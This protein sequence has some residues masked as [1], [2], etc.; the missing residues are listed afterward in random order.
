MTALT[1]LVT[2]GSG[3]LGRPL[4]DQLR[5]DRPG[6]RIV[7]IGR[8]IS[9]AWPTVDFQAADLESDDSL[10]EAVA[11]I[12]PDRVV[13]LAGRTPPASADQ[14]Y[15]SNVIGTLKLLDALRALDR[16]MRIVLAGSAAEL[17]PVR[18]ANL[19]VGEDAPCHPVGPYG[20]SKFLATTAGLAA[21]PPLE[22]AVARVF[23]P[24]GPGMPVSQAFGRFASALASGTGPI[25]LPVGDLE[26]RRDFIDVRD[27]ARGLLA[28]IER[29]HCGRVY[30]VGTGRSRRVGDGL[31]TLIALSGREVT[32]EAGQAPPSVPADSRADIARI[33]RETGWN[34][35]VPWE[36]S[37]RD[38][39]DEAVRQARPRD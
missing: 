17:G 20:L 36:Q 23:N 7:A 25:R 1:W 18:E 31:D 27:V 37:L 8:S 12:R 29:G 5:A 3:F 35:A 21:G 11:E 24:I 34:P 14:L 33:V 6:D 13:H 10:A 22:V 9:E 32:V 28:I 15:R 19:P 38:L 2:G 16:P 4:L 39:W 30:L 26:A